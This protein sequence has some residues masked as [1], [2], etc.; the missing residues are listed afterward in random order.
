[1]DCYLFDIDGTLADITHRLHH[2]QGDKKNWDA[3]FA[4]CV[5]DKPIEP[6][7]DLARA[8]MSTSLLVFVSGRSDKVR[9]ETQ[10]WL[11]GAVGV[12][13]PLYM[14][15]AGDRRPDYIVKGELLDQIISD[16]YQPIMAFDDRRQVV[17]MWRSRG[18]VC[19]Q[20]A[21]GDF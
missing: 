12:T 4:D 1:V 3:F 8:L 20:V 17:D 5:H 9:A 21:E 19:C 14:R 7:C 10:D 18:I 6:L 11:L 13:G 15:K 2:I 16:G